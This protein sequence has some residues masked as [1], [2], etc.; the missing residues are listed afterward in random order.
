[1]THKRPIFYAVDLGTEEQGQEGTLPGEED[2]ERREERGRDGR[3]EQDT[4]AWVLRMCRNWTQS[5]VKICGIVASFFPW[6]ISLDLHPE[7]LVQL[8]G[9]EEPG[10]ASMYF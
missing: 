3:G 5:P 1:M 9:G 2:G 8:T 4:V 10:V 7:I 6:E